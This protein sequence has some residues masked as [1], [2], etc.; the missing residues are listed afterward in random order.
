MLL[1]EASLWIG[2]DRCWS[3]IFLPSI[4]RKKL[5]LE[6]FYLPLVISLLRCILVLFV[7]RFVSGTHS[8]FYL[9]ADTLNLIVHSYWLFLRLHIFPLGNK[10]ENLKVIFR[11][12]WIFIHQ[13]HLTLQ[14]YFG[15]QTVTVC[16]RKEGRNEG[17]KE[18]RMKERLMRVINVY[19]STTNQW[20]KLNLLIIQSLDYIS[21][22]SVKYG[23]C[24]KCTLKTEG[25][26]LL[27]C[28]VYT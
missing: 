14:E 19:C 10:I 20:D 13:Y 7:I 6:K 8:L 3:Y 5:G 27:L 24:F 25:F 12:L 9:S 21:Y 1:K 17:R 18:R 2:Y 26:L 4:Y 16:E 11:I 23:I 22:P 15:A 28:Y